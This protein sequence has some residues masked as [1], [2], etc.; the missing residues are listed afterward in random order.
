MILFF[1]ESK[2]QLC[3]NAKFDLQG[4]SIEKKKILVC[5]ANANEFSL[6][7]SSLT[8]T[9]V[10]CLVFAGNSFHDLPV[11]FFA[12]CLMILTI[13]LHCTF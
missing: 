10:I 5:L 7:L 2:S 12:L 3:M 13:Q 8:V 6:L 9:F 4:T 11:K 1:N